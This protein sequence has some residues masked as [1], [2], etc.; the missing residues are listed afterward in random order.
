M[1]LEISE[2]TLPDDS[3]LF[4]TIVDNIRI[5]ENRIVDSRPVMVFTWTPNP[6]RLISYDMNKCHNWFL[7][8]YWKLFDRCMFDYVVV[9]EF[10]QNGNIH[11]HGW[12]QLKDPYKWNRIVLP[13]FKN[14]G[15]IKIN[16]AKHII[17][18]SYDQE[19]NALW[20]YKK[21]VT[22]NY[23]IFDIYLIRKEVFERPLVK[24]VK[25][26]KRITILDMFD[27]QSGMNTSLTYIDD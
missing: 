14:M 1:D 15:W 12:Y 27:E 16:T 22:D 5:I 20:Y 2:Q 18:N 7:R 25:K 11:Y 4:L 23:N 9:P 13:K 17:K 19:G 6:K 21:D 26:V 24:V 8:L 10:N 3:P